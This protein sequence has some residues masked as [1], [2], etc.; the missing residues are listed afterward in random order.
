MID[1]NYRYMDSRYAKTVEAYKLIEGGFEIYLSDGQNGM[2]NMRISAVADNIIKIHV[3]REKMTPPKFDFVNHSYFSKQLHAEA[4]D[5]DKSLC[6]SAKNCRAVIGKNPFSL[7]VYN[8]NDNVVYVEN[9]DDVNSV[10]DGEDR[11][12]PLGYTLDADGNVAGMNFCGRLRHDEHIYGLGER[13]T[14]FDRRG[15]RV[16]MWNYDTLGCRDKNAYKNVPFYVSSYGYGLFL[17]S[18]RAAEFNIGSESIASINVHCPGEEMEYYI[19]TGS[20][21]EI[22]ST[23]THLTG[24]AA[25]PPDWSFGLWFS[26]GFAGTNSQMVE[27]DAKKLRDLGIPSDVIHF[28]CYWLRDDMWCDFVWD[29]AMYPDR[30]QM[31]KRIKDMGYKICLWINPY[32][33][34]KTEMYEEGKKHGYFAKNSAGEP[35]QADLWHGLLSMCVLLDVTNPD[36]VDWFKGKLRSVLSEGVDVLKTDFGED[37]PADCI[38]ANGMTGEEMRN[39]YSILYNEIVF[40]ETKKQKSEEN[41]LVWA[42]SGYAGM[43]KYPVCWSGDPRSSYECMAGTLRSGLSLGMSGVP[44]WSHDIG[45]FYGHVSDEIYVRWAQFGLFS[46]HSRM[47][48]TTSRPPWAF[49]ERACKIVTDFIKLRYRLMPYILK[50]ARN[51]CEQGLPFIRPLV[52]E[53]SNDPSVPMI[54]DQYYFGKDMMVA[55]VFG[56]HN[57]SR[58]VYLPEGEW[59]DLLSGRYYMGKRWLTVKCPL[60]YMPIFVKNN[61]DIGLLDEPDMFISQKKS[62]R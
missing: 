53:D 32:V 17:N 2:L 4:V 13:F 42:R 43:Q 36:A 48:G 6:V 9:T 5:Q 16:T 10:G 15:Q 52:L 56:G 57:Q 27:A 28:D 55:P 1:K 51:C 24:P 26:T 3:A 29:D 7:T 49:S 60:D 46:S 54:Y 22:V 33:T 21:K 40:E 50:T 44:F 37:I 62:G 14:E 35:Y 38:F 31:L 59:Q 39:V 45:G 23:Y 61:A 34:I 25:L 18:H 58:S 20:L 41:G 47:H 19:I 30:L 12:M 8:Q 11:I